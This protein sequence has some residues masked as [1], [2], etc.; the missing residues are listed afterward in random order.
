MKCVSFDKLSNHTKARA[1]AGS[2]QCNGKLISETLHSLLRLLCLFN[3]V[4][5]HNSYKNNKRCQI[6]CPL[7]IQPGML[8]NSPARYTNCVMEFKWFLKQCEVTT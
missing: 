4:K 3:H 2:F 1:S 8:I 5:S 7:S 6:A